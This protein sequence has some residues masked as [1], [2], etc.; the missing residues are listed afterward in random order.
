MD[1][2]TLWDRLAGMLGIYAE[3]YVL[4]KNENPL[5]IEP[6]YAV[7]Y[8]IKD[9]ERLFDSKSI[10]DQWIFQIADCRDINELPPDLKELVV[11]FLPRFF[12]QYPEYET[13]EC[14]AIS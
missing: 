12:A 1:N 8:E 5:G 11:Q 3:N 13:A 9:V 7:D 6:S 4:A 14:L 10:Y 2:E